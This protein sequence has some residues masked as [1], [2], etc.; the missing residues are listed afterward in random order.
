MGKATPM[1]IPPALPE[2]DRIQQQ[3]HTIAAV[4]YFLYGMF[5]LFGAQYLTGMQTARRGMSSPRLFFVLGGAIALLFP[6]LIYRRWAMPLPYFWQPRA[7]RKTLRIN[8]TL[9]LGLLVFLRVIAL[10]RGGVFLHTWL[11]TAALVV[12]AMNATCLLW[13]GGSRPVWV[14]RAM[15]KS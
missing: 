12:A 1:V 7:E 13:A 4:G 5:Y 10:V 8:F 2:Q 15:G 6:W 3:H 9:L 11:H 14:T